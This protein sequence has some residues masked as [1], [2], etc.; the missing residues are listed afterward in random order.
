MTI[1]PRPGFPF[2]TPTPPFAGRR[3]PDRV[4]EG[5]TSQAAWVRADLAAD[6]TR[7]LGLSPEV[8]DD[9]VLCIAE[10][11]ANACAHTRSGNPGGRVVR[12]LSQPTAPT[13]RLTLVDGGSPTRPHIPTAQEEEMPAES[14]RGLLLIEHLSRAWGTR[15]APD[16]PLGDR[17]GHAVWAEFALAGTAVPAPAPEVAR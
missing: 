1:V 5:V 4:Y 6:L 17:P 2:H 3:W 15:P 14:G 10:M 16:H 13:V 8:R 7:L 9:A 12:L 11:F